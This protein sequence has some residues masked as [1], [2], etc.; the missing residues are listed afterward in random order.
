M[1]M[2][3]SLCTVSQVACKVVNLRAIEASKTI[4]P[5]TNMPEQLKREVLI[6]QNLRH[7]SGLAN[8]NDELTHMINAI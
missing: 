4:I 6:L 7:V 8:K 1:R 3:I 2:A 5:G